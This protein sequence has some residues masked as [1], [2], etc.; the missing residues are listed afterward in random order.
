MQTRPACGGCAERPWRQEAPPSKSEDLQT[1]VA[2]NVAA[3]VPLLID[4]LK[5]ARQNKAVKADRAF[6]LELAVEA[7]AT[8]AELGAKSDVLQRYVD[9]YRE[10]MAAT[11][12]ED[13][14]EELEIEPESAFGTPVV[15]PPPAAA[16]NHQ[17]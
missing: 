8:A 5:S 2:T 3:V 15:T 12:H 9:R 11:M 10:A 7:L 14:P 13:E 16:G 6:Q 4:L 1:F 17:L